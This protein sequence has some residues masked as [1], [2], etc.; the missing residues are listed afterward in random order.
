M[1]NKNIFKENKLMFNYIIFPKLNNDLFFKSE[2]KNYYS[3][4]SVFDEIK[5]VN[6][7]L[8]SKSHLSRVELKTNE[9]SYIYIMVKSMGKF[10][11]LS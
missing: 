8:I 2:I 4:L 6:S 11:L 10:L 9:M 1:N 7:E 3:D 5:N